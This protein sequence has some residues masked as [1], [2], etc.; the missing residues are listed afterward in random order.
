MPLWWNW[1]T[2]GTQ[3]PVVAIPCRF[4]PDQRH[5]KEKEQKNL[6][7]F[8]L[9]SLWRE[10]TRQLVAVVRLFAIANICRGSP[11]FERLFFPLCSQTETAIPDHYLFNYLFKQKESAPFPF[12]TALA[13]TCAATCCRLAIKIYNVRYIKRSAAIRRAD[14]KKPDCFIYSF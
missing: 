4:D 7:L 10:R 6:L 14:L 9:V 5:Q 8:L 11:F 12:D 1:Q 2:R 3:N 13:R